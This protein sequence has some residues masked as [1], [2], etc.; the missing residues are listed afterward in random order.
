MDSFPAVP[1]MD[2][3]DDD[4]I[5]LPLIP[6]GAPLAYVDSWDA[7]WTEFDAREAAK[8]HAPLPVLI[9]VEFD[10]TRRRKGTAAVETQACAKLVDRAFRADPSIV[11]Y[12]TTKPFLTTREAA[13]YCGFKT[14][15]ALRKAKLEGRIAPAGRRGG[16][17]TLMWNREA[18]DRYLQGNAPASVPGGRAR[19]PPEVNGGM[20]DDQAV[21]SEVEQ[22][23]GAATDSSRRLS[24][25]GGRVS[26]SRASCRSEERS[27]AAGCPKPA[28]PE[29][30]RGGTPSPEGGARLD[31][32]GREPA[33]EQAARALC[34]VRR[35]LAAR[36]G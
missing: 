25:E 13:A 15:G 27:D 1:M 36:K 18:L 12:A 6:H 22:L 33:N 35:F 14:A 5:T 21:G 17:G 4:A 32:Q 8:T 31:P 16:S 19:T 2:D 26:R 11:A 3:V 20:H 29:G 28:G 24:A 9:A 7:F 23:G 10:A 30:A 34:N